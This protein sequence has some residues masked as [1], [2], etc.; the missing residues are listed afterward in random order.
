MLN[1]KQYFADADELP[2]FNF[3]KLMT[4]NDLTYLLKD[5]SIEINQDEKIFLESVLNTLLYSFSIIDIKMQSLY[6]LAFRD[7]LTYKNDKSNNLK[8]RAN[9]S[10]TDYFNYIVKYFNHIILNNNKISIEN[11][12]NEL[13]K[14]SDY[15]NFMLNRLITFDFINLRKDKEIIWDL[16]D[17]V[18]KLEQIMGRTIDTMT[19]SVNKFFSIRKAA[20]ELIKAKKQAQNKQKN[21]KN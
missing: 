6:F 18:V 1:K 5:N 4:K 12:Y 19:T 9:K 10:F 20:N 16:N 14:D 11:H 21:G 8:T 7:F 15:D 17:E 13:R 3:W 2:I